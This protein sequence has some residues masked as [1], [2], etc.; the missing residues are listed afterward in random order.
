MKPL[1]P[2][3]I[4]QNIYTKN[5]FKNKNY[6]TFLEIGSGNGYLS[7]L[8][9][10]HNLTG[11]GYDLN[12]SAC[13][14]NKRLNSEFLTKEKYKVYNQNFIEIEIIEKFDIIISS[15]VIEHL[16]EEELNI[17][18]EKAKESLNLGGLIILLVPSSMKYWGIEDEI[19]GHI[20][21]Y[22]F[23]D[24]K[25]FENQ[26][27]LKIN[28]IA[29]L[30]YPLSNW[31]FKLSNSIINKNEKSKLELNQKER[32]IYT[33]NREVSY[34]T[35]F[36]LIF[37]LILNKYVL[38]PFHLLQLLNRNNKNSLVIYCEFKVV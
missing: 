21:R 20:K 6:K 27:N 34:K 19:A 26:Y 2:G 24:F 15:M 14:N 11:V 29:G 32:T 7:N 10:S 38:W 1:P 5:R 36:P 35:T 33:G 22:E 31:F 13:E 25:N 17:F 18:L 37:K 16:E 4:L 8:L 3:N 28:H 12:S 9:L 30:T 23:D